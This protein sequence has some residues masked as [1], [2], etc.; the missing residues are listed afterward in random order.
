LL[1]AICISQFCLFSWQAPVSLNAAAGM[2]EVEDMVEAEVGSAVVGTPSAVADSVDAAL[3]AAATEAGAFTA[4]AGTGMDMAAS[5]LGSVLDLA[6][7]TRGIGADII[8]RIGM[9]TRMVIPTMPIPIRP[10]MGTH[11]PP[12]MIRLDTDPGIHRMGTATMIHH[13]RQ[14][15][16]T[17]T[18]AVASGITSAKSLV[19]EA[20]PLRSR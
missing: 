5:A 6:T 9:G 11:M 4:V 18:R 13:P 2:V 10:R 17:T 20:M 7:A 16:R 15:P 3:Q 14:Q 1:C 8:I 19:R 12:H